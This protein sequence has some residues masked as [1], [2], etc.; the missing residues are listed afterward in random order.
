MQWLKYAW[1]NFDILSVVGSILFFVFLRRRALQLNI[2]PV[3]QSVL[4][5]GEM[6]RNQAW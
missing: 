6:K 5:M 1:T 3:T 2:G 4:S